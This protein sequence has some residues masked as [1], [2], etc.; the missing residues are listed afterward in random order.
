LFIVI[1][2]I[3]ALIR[4]K[5]NKISD[6]TSQKNV[7]WEDI[8]ENMNTNLYK[9]SAGNKPVSFAHRN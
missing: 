2:F 8:G 6:G 9:T 5:W 7:I 3:A 1:F 4:G